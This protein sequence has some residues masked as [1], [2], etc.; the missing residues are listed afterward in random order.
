[1]CITCALQSKHGGG[2]FGTVKAYGDRCRILLDGARPALAQLSMMG[3]RL[4]RRSSTT[5]QLT[6]ATRSN[7][8]SRQYSGE[9]SVECEHRHGGASR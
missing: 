8:A 4:L 7:G 3:G 1:M 5:T 6:Y 2:H 9:S